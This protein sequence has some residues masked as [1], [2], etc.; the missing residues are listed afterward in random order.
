M[1][2]ISYKIIK[3]KEIESY[4]K[5]IASLR[6]MMFKEFPYLY[7]GSLEQEEK[8]LSFYTDFPDGRVVLAKQ[9][10][11]IAGLLT[12]MPMISICE[13]I[14]D[15]KKTLDEHKRTLNGAYYY[16][17]GLVLPAYRGQGMLT[18]M[19][20]VLN[21]EIK[22]MGYNHAYGITVIRDKNDARRPAHYRDTDTLWDRMGLT[23]TTMVYG[24]KWPTIIKTG[25]TAIEM[26]Y[27]QIWEKLF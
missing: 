22:I 20:E 17:E 13:H 15:F 6:L 10:G 3:N 1:T 14:S 18:K 9:G 23:K 8:Y 11:C 16:G 19:F 27:L 2:K 24:G 12:G 4:T 5:Y 21:N 25:D 7:E 26:N